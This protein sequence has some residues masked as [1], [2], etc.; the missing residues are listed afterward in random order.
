MEL[1]HKFDDPAV[2][3]LFV[4]IAY[5]QLKRFL[6][7]GGEGECPGCGAYFHD[8]SSSEQD[9]L[10]HKEN[11]PVQL[12]EWKLPYETWKSLQGS[13]RDYGKKEMMIYGNKKMPILQGK[14]ILY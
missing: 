2:T 1:Q 6:R 12:L 5:N 8:G 13:R 4:L 14:R 7:R 9:R 11:C 3:E 10:G